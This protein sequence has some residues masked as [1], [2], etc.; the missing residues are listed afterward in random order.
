LTRESTDGYA[1]ERFDRSGIYP[2]TM[3]D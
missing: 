1:A 3:P 2:G